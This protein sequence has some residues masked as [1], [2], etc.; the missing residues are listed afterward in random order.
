MHRYSLLCQ[1]PIA[2]QDSAP[3]GYVKY[4]FC[5]STRKIRQ[6]ISDFLN[7]FVTVF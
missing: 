7:W 3:T 6:C 4:L 5:S 1:I 2:E